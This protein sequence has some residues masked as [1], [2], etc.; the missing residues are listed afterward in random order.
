M[1][2]LYLI[3][4]I[5]LLLLFAMFRSTRLNDPVKILIDKGHEVQICHV[6]LARI[7]PFMSKSIVK[8][9]VARVQKAKNI[10]TIFNSSSNAID[11]TV[12]EKFSAVIFK[13]ALE[14]F[15]QAES[16]EISG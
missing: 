1:E 6:P 11:I 5:S 3:G 15:P 2:Y 10:I 9:K 4:P 13:R 14:L 12:S 16:I 7:L 8:S